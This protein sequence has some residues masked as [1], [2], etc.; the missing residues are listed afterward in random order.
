MKRKCS[1]CNG[2]TVIEDN[3]ICCLNPFCDRTESVDNG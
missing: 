3:L 1:F 2:S